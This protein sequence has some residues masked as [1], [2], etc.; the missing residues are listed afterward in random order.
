MSIPIDAYAVQWASTAV[1]TP[2]HKEANPV[3]EQHNLQ[4]F[5]F[6]VSPSAYKVQDLEVTGFLV[7]Q[8]ASIVSWILWKAAERVVPDLGPVVKDCLQ[9]DACKQRLHHYHSD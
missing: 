1:I 8:S 4:T 5:K 7:L 3:Q 2:E 6:Y 9:P